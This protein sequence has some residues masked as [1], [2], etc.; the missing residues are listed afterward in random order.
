LKTGGF[1]LDYEESLRIIEESYVKET[2]CLK[3]KR[4]RSGL[5]DHT[6][7]I[8]YTISLDGYLRG[9]ADRLFELGI[10]P[11]KAEY[12]LDC[13]DRQSKIYKVGLFVDLRDLLNCE[14]LGVLPEGW[15]YFR[16]DNADGKIC[17]IGYVDRGHYKGVLAA[18]QRI[19]EIAKEFEEFLDTV[20]SVTVNALLLLSGD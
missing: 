15:R 4:W 20:D 18:K 6:C 5:K 3:C 13:D 2:Y 9:I 17:T 8:K 11:K 12:W 19:K 14:V 10:P 16:E 1:R 7:P